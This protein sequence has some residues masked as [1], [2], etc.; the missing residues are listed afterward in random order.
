MIDENENVF[1]NNVAELIYVRTKP[2]ID[3]DLVVVQRPVR[4]SDGNE[5]VGIFPMTWTPDENSYEMAATPSPLA[6]GEPTIQRYIIGVQGLIKDTD[7]QRGIRK[8]AVLAKRLRSM[9]YR[10]TALA[11]G[12]NTLSVSMFGSVE[13]IQKRGILVQRYL[14]NELQGVFIFLSSIEYYVET[15]TG[16]V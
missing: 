14:N 13:R 11:V 8:H 1:P 6:A 2:A 5:V 16:S 9:L 3:S 10:D 4:D 12:L 7:E 15:Q